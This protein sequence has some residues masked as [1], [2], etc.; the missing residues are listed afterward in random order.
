[1]P[2]NGSGV[3]Q[4]VRNWV[5]DATA[6]I[7]IRAD[8]H[9]AEDDG[10]AAGLTNCITKDGQTVVTQNIPFNS[11]RITG[12]ADPVNPQDAA[13]MA[14]T[15]TRVASPG[16]LT[17]DINI[18][19]GSPTLILNSTDAGHSALSGLKNG[20]QRWLLRL[21]NGAVE[22]GSNVGSD[23]DLHRYADD[24]AY[25]GQVMSAT[26]SDGATTF[27]GPM[28][29]PGEMYV[30]YG[31][32]SAT[33]RF[34]GTDSGRYLHWSGAYWVLG[35][36]KLSLGGQG[37][38]G[39]DAV[40]WDQLNTKQPNLGFTPVQQSG[41]AYQAGNKVYIGWDNSHLR[42]QVDNVDL[43]TFVFGGGNFVVNGRLL[44]A[45]NVGILNAASGQFYEPYGGGVIV[46]WQ[47]LMGGAA[48]PAI[49][50]FK[51]RWMQLL[52]HRLVHSGDRADEDQ[53]PR[54][55]ATLHARQAAGRRT[56]ERAVRAPRRAT[57]SIGTTTSIPASTSPRTASR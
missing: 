11:K 55:M 31:G 18:S 35:G 8:Y 48:T 22:T 27:N 14:F 16:T 44:I 33:I 57:A 49:V 43:G 42:A 56:C 40:T 32:A 46:G 3:F 7:K 9:D 25:L 37:T 6:G 36:G 13:T 29:T 1:M 15:N 21:G 45:G 20:K 5:A 12:L 52:H 2:F 26:R 23:F 54:H 34:A 51:L 50:G 41:G 39:N 28:R 47:W 38:G 19:K 4:R 17:G 30:G 24:G 10:F 53:G